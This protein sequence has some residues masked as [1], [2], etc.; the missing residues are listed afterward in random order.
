MSIYDLTTREST[1]AGPREWGALVVLMLPVL[2]T[3]IDNTVL[4]FALPQVSS[5]LEPTGTQLM[6]LVDIYP[7]ILAGFLVAM[8]SLGDRVGRRRLLMLGASG[9][10]VASVIAAYSQSP[11]M[12]LGARALLGFFGATL[13]PS[14]MS[15]IRNIFIDRRERQLAIAS[16]G[17]MFAAG[18]ALGPVIGGWLLA[19][20]WWGSVFLINVPVLAVFLSLG[21]LLLPESRDP[22]PGPLDMPSIALSLVAMLPLVMALKEAGAHGLSDTVLMAGGVGISAAVAFVLRQRRL[23]YPMVDVTLFSNRV[24]T[25]AISSNLLSMMAYV[26][27]LFFAAQFLQLV[28]GLSPMRAAFALVPGLLSA[29]VCGFIAVGLVRVIAPNVVVGTSFAFAGIGYAVAAFTG[30]LGAGTFIIAFVLM[31]I[32]IGLAETLTNDLMLATVPAHKAGA[33]SAL[34]ETAYEIG[35]VLGVAVLGSVLTLT[36][37]AHLTLP[38]QT[39]DRHQD[40]YETLGGTMKEAAAQPIAV[41]EQIRTAADSAFD[42][43][44]QHTSAVAIVIVLMSAMIAWRTL[45]SRTT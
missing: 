1:H 2:L 16:W 37:R 40:A 24:F 15:L 3:S 29:I 41:G 28:A 35:A 27:F 39:P 9:F 42:V 22:E 18:A 13:M 14:T 32:G 11:T 38:P 26:G 17:S 4:T 43:A 12:L 36:Y 31:G 10:G 25:G 21:W 23:T 5:A 20:S 6:W 44:V 8:G 45:P 34:S 7:L 30:E 19:H 33:A